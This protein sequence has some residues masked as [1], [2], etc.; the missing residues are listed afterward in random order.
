MIFI[1][2]D[3]RSVRKSLMRLM[4]A[5]GY[6]AESFERAEEYFAALNEITTIDC[7]ILDLQMPGMSGLDLQAVINRR[8]PSV[9]VIILSATE[10]TELRAKA[11]AAGAAAV[12]R[13]PC[14]WTVLLRAVV[15][16]TGQPPPCPPTSSWTQG[17]ASIRPAQSDATA[18]APDLDYFVVEAAHAVYRPV[19][20]VS[21]DEM[22]ALVRDAISAA[23]RSEV[24]DLLV[25]IS[26]L[27]GFPSPNT[28]ERLVAAVEWAEEARDS[29]RL[30]M[31]ARPEMIHPQKFGVLAA[32]NRGM[33]SNIFP[34]E[35][36]AR[37]W[38][39]H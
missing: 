20:A 11:L 19:G 23:I 14:D 10:D 5:A 26:G 29:V 28:L 35:Q 8:E 17:H 1:V 37:D 39:A 4:R 18:G 21:F 34:T 24:R 15:K 12:L 36:E 6:R 16:A 38:L 25:D 13:K 32:H 7:V 27:T 31:V 9:P 2:D 22:V 3:D 30:A 33:I